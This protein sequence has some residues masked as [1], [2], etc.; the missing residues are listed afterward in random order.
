MFVELGQ[1]MPDLQLTGTSSAQLA[2][3][4]RYLLFLK[5]IKN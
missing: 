5:I 4:V 1:K 3:F 2:C